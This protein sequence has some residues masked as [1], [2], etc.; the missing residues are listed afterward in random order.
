MHRPTTRRP[1]PTLLQPRF[2]LGALHHLRERGG[3]HH[4]ELPES[5]VEGAG[6]DY[7]VFGRRGW[8]HLPYFGRGS[9]LPALLTRDPK[10]SR[11][12][13]LLQ[14]GTPSWSPINRRIS[15]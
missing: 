3:I 5:F 10:S 15:T 13:P 7:Y 8:R 11:F 4:P 6:N 14:R 9:R 12:D 1:G 2:L